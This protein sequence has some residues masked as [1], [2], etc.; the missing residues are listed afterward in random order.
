[1]GV[2]NRELGA[3]SQSLAQQTGKGYEMLFQQM[4]NNVA[5]EE[6]ERRITQQREFERSTYM[7]QEADRAKR[8]REERYW[9]GEQDKQQD[10]MARQRTA[11]EYKFRMRLEQEKQKGDDKRYNK[12]KAETEARLRF[13]SDLQNVYDL[14]V[15]DLQKKRETLMRQKNM[16]GQYAPGVEEQLMQIENQIQWLSQERSNE[17]SA[18]YNNK[19]YQRQK[20]QQAKVSSEFS[21]MSAE[22]LMQ[23]GLDADIAFKIANKK[24]FGYNQQLTNPNADAQ[25]N[26]NMKEAD[27]FI[28]KKD[29]TN[30]VDDPFGLR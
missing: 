30:K 16:F 11:E 19:G 29:S 10:L 3:F 27:R 5:Q 24:K 6:A 12:A 18:F 4:F 23:G 13:E 22:S 8:A 20:Y 26:P 9:Q 15:I 21:P 25:R 1:M 2:T 7:M 28:G 17:S 14:P